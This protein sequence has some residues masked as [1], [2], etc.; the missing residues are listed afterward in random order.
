MIIGGSLVKLNGEKSK[1]A[2]KFFNTG[3]PVAQSLRL[4]YQI[5]TWSD[6]SA[7]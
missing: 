7:S 4:S 2:T 3:A 1:E 6:P 5:S